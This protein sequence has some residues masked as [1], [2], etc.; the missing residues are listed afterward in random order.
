MNDA[1]YPRDMVGYGR[2]PPDPQWPNGARM[3][4][5]LVVNYEEGSEASFADGDG[6]SESPMTDLGTGPKV[7]G[8]DLAAESLLEYGTRVGF[9]RL[10]DLFTQRGIALSVAGAALA[11]ERNPEAAA[12]IREAGWE[13]L[14]HGWRWTYQ[15]NMDEATEREHIRRAV[16]SITRT[17][18]TRP[19]GWAC[20]YGPS[21]NTRRLLMEA[22]FTYDC[23]SYADEL[24]Y[25][26]N[27]GGKPF[28][29][30]PHSFAHNDNKYAHGWFG[31]PSDFVNYM[32]EAFDFMYRQAAR[33]PQLMT[34]ALHL[35]LSGHPARAAALERFLDHVLRHR[36]VWVSTR[37]DVARHWARVC[38]SR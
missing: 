27:E 29:V 26:A 23:N 19:A 10:H 36:D 3:A 33:R 15:Y 4:F 38:P 32:T 30:L 22:G 8:R 34:L 9:W 16:E 7:E 6:R 28:L 5:N 17:F 14:S 11:L 24:P 1:A 20:R 12:A 31:P 18:G 21:L 13:V 37:L 35:R 2:T 25:W